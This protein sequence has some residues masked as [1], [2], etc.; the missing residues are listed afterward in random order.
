MIPGPAP[1]LDSHS[2]ETFDIIGCQGE[3]RLCMPLM[4][5]SMVASWETNI[6][7]NSYPY[8]GNDRE[9]TKGGRKHTWQ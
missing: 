3:R 1:K 8:T 5:V 6:L 9:K 7:C 4:V 2:L